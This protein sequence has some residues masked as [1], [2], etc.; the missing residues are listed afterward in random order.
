MLA[1]QAA[2]AS[3]NTKIA[4]TN[5]QRIPSNRV[6]YPVSGIATISA[7]RYAVWIQTI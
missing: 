2:E 7:V 5:S 1:A 6:R 3:V 4:V